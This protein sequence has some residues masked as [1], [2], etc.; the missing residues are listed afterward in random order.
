MAQAYTLLLVIHIIAGFL[1]VILFWIPVAAKKGS[2]LHNRTGHWYAK[3]MY[4]VGFTAL[5]LSL[6]LITDPIAFKYADS[7]LPAERI[8]KLVP[9]QRDI[10][11]FLLAISIL[12]LTGVR[13]GLQTIQAKGNHAQMRRW[14]NISIHAILL[15]VGIILGINAGGNSPLS[16]LFYIFAGLCAFTAVENLRFCVK[17]KVTRAEQIVAHLSAIIGAGIGA[18]TAFFV[19]G[20]SHA[21]ASVLSGYMTMIPWVLPGL[22]GNILIAQQAKKYKPRKLTRV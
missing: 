21:L 19:F 8:S 3:A 20:A 14:N 15:A 9:A 17:P 11:L 18:H 12:T 7:E 5:L 22:V 2:A 10:G 4:A 16:V 1:S 13:H 6:M